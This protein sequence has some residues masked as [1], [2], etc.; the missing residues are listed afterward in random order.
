MAQTLVNFRMD[1]DL[2]QNKVLNLFDS[3][4]EIYESL[5]D[6]IKSAQASGQEQLIHNDK[7]GSLY[8]K[9]PIN[10]GKFK[11]INFEL[12]G[13]EYTLEENYK[14]LL[15]VVNDLRKRVKSLEIQNQPGKML[16]LH[17]NI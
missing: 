15:D 2:K 6:L 10:F 9:I 13:Q 5:L 1:E 3:I 8:L 17:A 11:D 7:E 4:N 16:T 14:N 12:K